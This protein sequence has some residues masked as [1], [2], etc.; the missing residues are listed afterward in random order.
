M[1]QLTAAPMEGLTGAVYR[2]LHHRFFGG[3]DAYYIPFV[4]TRQEHSI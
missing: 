3:A 2:K 1:A 4:L